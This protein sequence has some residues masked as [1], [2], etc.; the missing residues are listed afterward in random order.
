MHS[1]LCVQLILE[2]VLQLPS[3]GPKASGH[4]VI[5]KPMARD[6]QATSVDACIR[7]KPAELSAALHMHVTAMSKI[8]LLGPDRYKAAQTDRLACW[9]ADGCLWSFE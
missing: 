5:Y 1:A 4:H 2:Y 3:K 8:Y 6:H 7:Y 9:S